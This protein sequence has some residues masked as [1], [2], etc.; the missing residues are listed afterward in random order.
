MKQRKLLNLVRGN[1]FEMFL[2]LFL[3][4]KSVFRVYDSPR[5]GV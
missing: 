5:F 4:K 3:K 1:L 2:V